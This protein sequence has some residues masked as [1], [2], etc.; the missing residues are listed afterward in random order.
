MVNE[1]CSTFSCFEMFFVLIR[2]IEWQLAVSSI[3]VIA[4]VSAAVDD[5]NMHIE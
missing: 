4:C 3:D 5:I 2:I 1:V